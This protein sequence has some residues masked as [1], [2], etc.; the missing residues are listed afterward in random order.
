MNPDFE[1]AAPP[2]SAVQGPSDIVAATLHAKTPSSAHSALPTPKSAA[3][4]RPARLN[5]APASLERDPS[6]S[7]SVPSSPVVSQ[8]KPR[9]NGARATELST[10]EE[11]DKQDLRQTLAGKPRRRPSMP[12]GQNV[13]ASREIAPS[14]VPAPPMT[15]GLIASNRVPEAWR[16]P[17][18]HILS[19]KGST[20]Q[21]ARSVY[22]AGPIEV[23]PG[24]FLGDEHNARDDQM[25]GDYGITTILNVAKETVLPFQSDE[26][27]TPLREGGVGYWATGRYPSRPAS[28]TRPDTLRGMRSHSMAMPEAEEY[29][30]P[31]TSRFVPDTSSTPM[32]A[33]FPDEAYLTPSQQSPVELTPTNNGTSHLLRNT[34]STPNL[35]AEFKVGSEEPDAAPLLSEGSTVESTDGSSRTSDAG[36]GKDSPCSS[37]TE[38]TSPSE[39]SDLDPTASK[40]ADKSVETIVGQQTIDMS[41]T[42]EVPLPEDAVKLTIPPSPVSGRPQTIRYIKLPWTHDQSELASANGGFSQGCAV[43][44]EALGIDRYGRRLVDEATGTPMARGNILVHCQ[45]GVSRSAT[46]VIAFVM[47][48]AA[49]N[50]PWEE[51]KNLNTMHECYDRVKE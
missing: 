18:E 42:S 15:S 3:R 32:T 16:D 46:L 35:Q 41:T 26:G 47:Q 5:L 30:T 39:C 45:C 14:A 50:Y 1:D 33:R 24:L 6:S 12:F 10:I 51:T 9:L 36:T 44:A 11:R 28:S 22:A 27:A 20:L 4:K 38:A 25:L 7:K 2:A 34:L 43:I 17:S 40:D 21:H 29:Y 31:M 48:S 19:G 8:A 37:S 23:L 49:Y 13:R